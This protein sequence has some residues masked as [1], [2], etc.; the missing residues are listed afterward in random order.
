[1]SVYFAEIGNLPKAH[2]SDLRNIQRL[3]IEEWARIVA[4]LRA[5]LSAV[6]CRF[7]VHAA[8][9]LSLDVGQVMHFRRTESNQRR[10]Q[11][12]MLAVL[13]G[14]RGVPVEEASS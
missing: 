1:M 3:N 13:V 6:E 12:L 4:E 10:V 8:L 2:R 5:D 14:N 7:L 11:Q 9:I